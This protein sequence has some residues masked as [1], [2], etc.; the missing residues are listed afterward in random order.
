MILGKDGCDIPNFG[1]PISKMAQL[2]AIMADP[3][4]TEYDEELRRMMDCFMKNPDLIAGTDRFD[5]IV[6]K[7]YPGNIISKAGAAGL[8][9]MAMK[10]GDEWLGISVKIIDGSYPACRHLS[11]LVL[12]WLGD[13]P[14][15]PSRRTHGPDD[16]S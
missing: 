13:N 4:G 14:Q 9:T 10:I 3:Q 15:V 12:K 1:L 2:F 6:M 7:E 16:I 8:Q 5:T 11:Y